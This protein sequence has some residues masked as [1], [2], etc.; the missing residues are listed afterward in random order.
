MLESPGDVTGPAAVLTQ[1]LQ[2][3]LQARGSDPLRSVLHASSGLQR[4]EKKKLEDY[5]RTSARGAC[6]RALTCP[7]QKGAPTIP[8]ERAGGGG[9][10]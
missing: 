10:W 3:P 2:P 9:C 4:T 8:A 6:P 1:L 7:L 5:T